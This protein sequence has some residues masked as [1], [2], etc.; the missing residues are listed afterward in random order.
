MLRIDHISITSRPS[1]ATGVY[2]TPLISVSPGAASTT[3]GSL[4]IDHNYLHC[5]GATQQCHAVGLFAISNV[6]V[7]NNLVVMDKNTS[8]GGAGRFVLW[9]GTTTPSSGLEIAYNDVTVND[10]IAARIWGAMNGFFPGLRIHDNVFR[11]IT[12]G[13][14]FGAV[15]LGTNSVLLEDFVNG[16]V[17]NNT[18]ELMG[19]HGV[20]VSEAKGVWVFS[21]TV[22]C[23]GQPCVKGF[24]LART[25]VEEALA[26]VASGTN[27]TVSNNNVSALTSASMPAVMVCKSPTSSGGNIAY[28]C[29]YSATIALSTSGTVCNSGIAV[30]NGTIKN[31]IPPCP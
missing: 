21:N 14:Y 31:V 15:H 3:G 11:H 28:N 12:I 1:V 19:G 8:N 13:T 24:Y 25:D 16:Q 5:I 6:L 20:N 4:E 27:M 26:A 30:G 23:G 2:R 22:T 17:Y 7:D 18:F 29:A 10:Q 9:E